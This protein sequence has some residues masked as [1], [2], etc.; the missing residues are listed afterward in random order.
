MKVA[1]RMDSDLI[2]W[3]KFKFVVY[4]VP[5]LRSTYRERY[6]ELGSDAVFTPTQ[7][8]HHISQVF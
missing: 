1:N 8:T 2:D 7:L 6:T 4:D 5:N 3:D